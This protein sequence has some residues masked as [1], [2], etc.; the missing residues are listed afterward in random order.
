MIIETQKF[1]YEL[2]GTVDHVDVISSDPPVTE[3]HGRFTTAL[4]DQV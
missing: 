3:W 1:T 2:E 4:T